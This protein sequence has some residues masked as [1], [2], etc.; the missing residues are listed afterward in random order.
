MIIYV[1][2]HGEE[3]VKKGFTAEQL[4]KL[5][6]DEKKFVWIDLEAPTEKD[7]EI[8][9]DVF[10]FHH[11]TVEDCRVNHSYPKI[12]AFPDYLYFIVHGVRPDTSSKF[13]HTKELDGYLGK[14]YLVTYHHE[15]FRSID[16]VKKRIMSSPVI[17]QRGGTYLLHEI[18]D[19]LVDLYNP[20]IE[21][22]EASIVRLENKIFAIKNADNKM[23]A[24]IM[25][26]KRSVMRLRRI[27]SRQLSVLYR[28][29]HGEFELIEEGSL[30]FFRDIYDHLLRV[31][32]LAESYRDLV[33]GLLE[34]Y[35]SVIANRTNE[36]MKVL[37]IFSAIMLPLSLIAGI[38]G[39]NF[40]FMPELKSPYGYFATLMLMGMV[41]LGLLYYFW[42][43]GWIG[44]STNSES[45]IVNID[46]TDAP[47]K[48]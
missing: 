22:F 7:E 25:Q 29:S 23:L 43:K 15:Q 32:D 36:I 4:P 14:N 8:L 31:S 13:F 38:Y 3:C 10:K 46:E 42:R 18:L 12:E 48:K 17:C 21:D 47:E 9:S 37:A 24:E 26:L 6:G 39:M 20:V 2:H 27:S 44:H 35:L 34:A 16:A 11:L 41:A 40:E 5:L 30:P 19:L 1:Y 28:L 33:N 45:D